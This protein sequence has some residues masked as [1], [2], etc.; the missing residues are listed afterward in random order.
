M[1]AHGLDVIL[2]IGT[3]LAENVVGRLVEL[4]ENALPCTR[5]ASQR[6][7]GTR[8]GDH[9]RSARQSKHAS[10]KQSPIHANLHR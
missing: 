1:P 3:V 2:D 6:V 5:D 8:N 4:I 10:Q 7:T 9:R